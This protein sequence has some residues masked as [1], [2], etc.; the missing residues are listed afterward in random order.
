MSSYL[1]CG[2]T[3]SMCEPKEEYCSRCG[4][5]YSDHNEF[6]NDMYVIKDKRDGNSFVGGIVYDSY[7]EVVNACAM[8]KCYCEKYCD[9][10]YEPDY[11]EDR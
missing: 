5:S 2:V 4:H 7:G 3:D 11:D 8:K 6:D 9:G 10:E 1:P